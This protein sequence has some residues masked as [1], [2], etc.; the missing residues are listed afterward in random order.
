MKTKNY[1]SLFLLLFIAPILMAQWSTDPASPGVVCDASGIQSDP[2]SF[3]DGNGGIYVFWLDHRNGTNQ[4][5]RDV[6]GQHFDSDGNAL[7]E[8]DGIEIL[9]H[10]TKISWF[11]T[12]RLHNDEIIIGWVS[13]TDGEF[14]DS[15][16]IQRLDNNGQKDWP[17]DLL[18]SNT[19]FQPNA[20]LGLGGYHIIHDNAGYCIAIQTVHYGG[21]NRNRIT[22]FSSDGNLLGPYSGEPEGNA[23]GSS[24]LKPAFDAGNSV[25]LYYSSGNGAGANMFCLKLNMSGDTIWGPLNVLDGTAGLNYQFTGLSDDFGITFVWQGNGPGGSNT[26]LYARRLNADGTFAWNGNSLAI[27]TADGEQSRFYLKKNEDNYY[28]TWADGRPGVS[29]GNYDIYAQKFDI[30]G[31]YLWAENGIEVISLSTYIPH[32]EFDFSDNNSMIICHQ[33]SNIGFVAQK[34]LD[35][36]T[37]EWDADGNMICIPTF[38]PFYSEHIE[39][40]TG[41]KTIAVWAKTQPGG[42]SNDIYI[43]RVDDNPVTGKNEH[44]IDQLQISPNPVVDMINVTFSENLSEASIRILDAFGREVCRI[45]NVLNPQYGNL[46]IS[47]SELPAGLYILNIESG[48]LNYSGKFVKK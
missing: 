39:V 10:A 22:R 36:G 19:G 47:T 33:A 27:C 20:I 5:A 23:Y 15:L 16:K 43:T 46:K 1:L 34:V 3:A 6:Y 38:S 4:D 29:P 45:E 48:V 30:N 7:W 12:S 9:H 18:V 2:Q 35:D 28:I 25:Y 32:P 26:N 42:G 40:Q 21:S 11:N 41:D 44:P 13:H 17:A 24:G 31:N 8:E 14:G 37:V